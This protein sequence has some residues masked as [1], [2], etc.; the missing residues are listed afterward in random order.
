MRME[1]K[2]RSLFV[3]IF[4]W[5]WLVAA[6]TGVTLFVVAV[7]VDSARTRDVQR[8]RGEERRRQMAQML[9]FYGET[10]AKLAALEGPQA[11]DAYSDQLAQ[12]VGIHPYFFLQPDR[13]R[14]GRGVPPEILELARRAAQSG[15]LEFGTRR[16]EFML[17]QPLPNPTGGL[18]IV[19]GRT[20]LDP[21]GGAY[22]APRKG[23][24]A[25]PAASPASTET[26]LLAQVAGHLDRY[27]RDLG[28]YLAITFLIGGAACYLLTWHLTAPLRR[29]R[30]VAQRLAEGDLSARVG[31]DLRRRGDEI[32]ALGHDIDRMAARIEE[33]IQSQQRLLRDI[34][35]ELRSPLAR[36]NVALELARQSSGPEPAAFLDRI[37]CEWNRLNELIGQLLTLTRLEGG[38]PPAD[39]EEVD[40]AVLL[41]AIARDAEFEAARSQRRV[42][43]G[44]CAPSRITGSKELL[45]RAMENVV[46]NAIRYTQA[47]TAVELSLRTDG[48][49]GDRRAVVEVRDHGSGVPEEDLPKIFLPFYRV[50]DG[51]E[52]ESGGV[53]VGLAISDRAVRL[54]GGTI[55]A[56]NAAGGGLCVRI[57]L[58]LPQ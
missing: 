13:P 58:P 54:H 26:G 41:T 25:P 34:S 21:T 40:L 4:L 37:E 3:K 20:Q 11:L 12:T 28:T 31:R 16:D 27:S 51:R 39:R 33:L 32:A 57:E 46:R 49:P 1:L 30:A 23:P 15:K 36:L 24:P 55:H 22:P 18:S 50:S 42:D 6:L 43:V 38:D 17:A 5:F 9:T 56:S 7:L 14:P 45:R 35:H 47:G 53:G 29:L 8:D 19:V 44:A 10:A 48:P 2:P 52:R